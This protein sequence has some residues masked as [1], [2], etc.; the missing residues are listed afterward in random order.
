MLVKRSCAPGPVRSLR[1]R[2][3]PVSIWRKKPVTLAIHEVA[4]GKL[5]ASQMDLTIEEA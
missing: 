4:D 5:D 3:R 2:R 1:R